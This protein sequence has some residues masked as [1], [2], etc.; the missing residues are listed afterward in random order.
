M[1]IEYAK[2]ITV[3]SPGVSFLIENDDIDNIIWQDG[4]INNITKAQI[5]A[6]QIELQN[7]EDVKPENIKKASAVDKLKALGLTEEDIS[8]LQ[9]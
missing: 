8:S 6:K 2:V 7:I 4:N 3:L 5:L 1:K 9:I